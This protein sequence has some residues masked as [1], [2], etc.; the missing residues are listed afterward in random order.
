MTVVKGTKQ[1]PHKKREKKNA[2]AGIQV[3]GTNQHWHTTEPESGS[4]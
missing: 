1:T 3:Y 4:H 2:V